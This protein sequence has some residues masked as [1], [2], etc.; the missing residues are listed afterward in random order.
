MSDLDNFRQETRAWLEENCPPAVKSA[1]AGG[2]ARHPSEA[3]RADWLRIAASRGYT[4]PTWP[5]EY[6]G[7][8]LSKQ[9][10]V[11]MRQEVARI[12]AYVPSVSFFGPSEVSE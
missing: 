8:G 4:T 11:I 12:G 1:E 10:E 3:E 2:E 9:E 7:G 6:G 5:S